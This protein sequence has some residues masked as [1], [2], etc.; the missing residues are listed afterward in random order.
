[1]SKNSVTWQEEFN[2]K[3]LPA[4]NPGWYGCVV[5]DGWKKIVL[6]TDAMLSH[7]DPNYCILQVKEKFGTLR[8]YFDTDKDGADR[9]I[10]FAIASHA[11]TRSSR[12]CEV[13]GGYGELRDD[14]PW[15]RTLCDD[16]M[17]VEANR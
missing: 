1:M 8:Y 16:C 3:R 14:M 4:D 12:T 5:G 10:M 6:E 11:E 9:Q 15:I 2:K 17:I 13:C 7:I